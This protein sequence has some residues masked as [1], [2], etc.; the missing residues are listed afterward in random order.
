LKKVLLKEVN[1]LTNGF[2][3]KSSNSDTNNS[4]VYTDTRTRDHSIN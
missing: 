1:L 4:Y 3:K 2:S